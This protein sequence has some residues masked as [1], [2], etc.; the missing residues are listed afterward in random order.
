MVTD[1]YKNLCVFRKLNFP[2]QANLAILYD[3]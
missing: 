1:K 3:A 2:F